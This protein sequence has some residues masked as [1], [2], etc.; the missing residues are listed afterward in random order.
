[1]NEHSSRIIVGLDDSPGGR[2]ALA[3]ALRDAARRHAVVEAVAA[4]R[5]PE[6]WA[7]E[8]GA[9]AELVGTVEEIRAD[10][11]RQAEGIV[12][13]VLAGMAAEFTRVPTVTVSAV[14]GSAAA[15][16]LNAARHADLLV[17]GNRGR[18]GFAST[19]LGSVSLQCVLHAP[20]PVTVVRPDPRSPAR[21]GA[22]TPTA[23]AAAT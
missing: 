8:Y 19:V 3:H 5:T 14:G 16:L 10:V 11:R 9:A 20:C 13:E 12:E 17:V 21:N 22:A 1:M 23:G 18:G 2:A 6:F 4:F 15:A 7:S